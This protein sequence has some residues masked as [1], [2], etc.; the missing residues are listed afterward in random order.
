MDIMAAA[1]ALHVLAVVVWIGG[2]SM[3][4]AVVLPALRR[5]DLGPDWLR[6]FQAIEHRFVWWARAAV[7]VAGITGIWMVAD[8]D[9]WDRFRTAG[10]WWM[11]AMACLWL[12]FAFILF[13]GEPLI[14]HN[15]FM[16]M[17]QQE[18][19]RAFRRLHRVH[20]VLL[21]LSI[22]TIFG[23]VAGSHGWAVR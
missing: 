23:A 11:H 7:I 6:A 10:F 21:T 19:E 18:P 15:R 4:T 3:V 14:F 1:R 9:L 22:V 13:I 12:L 16:R 8:A 20:W 5:G 17:A 2:V